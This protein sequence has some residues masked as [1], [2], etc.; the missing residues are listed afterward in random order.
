MTEWEW[1]DQKSSIDLETVKS[2][3]CNHN[4]HNLKSTIKMHDDRL[5]C[6]KCWKV[7]GDIYDFQYADGEY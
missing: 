3:A 6:L 5:Y 4:P 1:P 7:I 2:M